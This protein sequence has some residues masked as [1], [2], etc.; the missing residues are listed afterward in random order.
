MSQPKESKILNRDFR[1]QNADAN[2][3]QSTF[4][5]MPSDIEIEFSV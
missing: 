2:T 3:V 4:S 1:R 5:G